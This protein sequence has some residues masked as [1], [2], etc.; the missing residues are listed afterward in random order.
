MSEIETELRDALHAA[1]AGARPPVDLMELVH[2]RRSS[3]RSHAAVGTMLVA[4]A[5]AALV[6]GVLGGARTSAPREEPGTSPGP[7]GSHTRTPSQSPFPG[8]RGW[9]RHTD[10]KGDSIGTP[11]TWH[12]GAF[13]ALA[14]PTVLWVVS[15]GPVPN[16]GRCAPTAALR[17]LPANGALFEVME[18]VSLTAQ[19]VSEPYAFPPRGSKLGLGSNGGPYEC[20][21]VKT[22]LVV[23]QD[24]GRY[25]QVQTVFGRAAS[26]ALRKQVMRS[27]NTLHVAPLPAHEQPAALCH[28]GKWTFC[29]EAAWVYQVVSAARVTQLGNLGTR[30]ISGLASNRSF[31]LWTTGGGDSLTGSRC[32]HVPGTSAC[33]VGQRI[34]WRVHGLIVWI[35]SAASPYSTTPVRPGLPGRPALKRLI[36]A[37]MRIGLPRK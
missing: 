14:A 26:A 15:T 2:Q 13:P 23:F 9:V 10:S 22:H 17:K 27:L 29:S 36:A 25:F 34:A 32:H 28:S 18:Y 1:V 16:G 5:A 11:A 24:G 30:A 7:G 6:G 21:G 12:V 20:W 35:E 31:A 33:R 3:R 4:L 37:S 8:L 19:R